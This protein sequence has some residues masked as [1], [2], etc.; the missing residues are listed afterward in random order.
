MSFPNHLSRLERRHFFRRAALAPLCLCLVAGLH[1]VRVW[2]CRQTPWKGGG[3]GMFSTVDDESARFVRCWLVTDSGEIPLPIPPAADKSLAELRAAPTQARLD[4]LARRLAQQNWRW[5][6]ERQV[7]EI[8]AVR[9]QDGV[10]ISSAVFHACPNPSEPTAFPSDHV[11][12]IP[13]NGAACSAIPFSKV[14]VECLRYRY[15]AAEKTLRTEAI[16]RAMATR[17][18][19]TP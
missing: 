2:A 10:A 12:P 8:A 9:Q 17:Q 18:E 4:D 19:A 11:E 14:R 13:R 3:F 16:L 15:T 7:H 5:R 1:F 6:D